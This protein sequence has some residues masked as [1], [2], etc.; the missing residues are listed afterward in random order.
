MRLGTT[1]PICEINSLDG[2]TTYA[3]RDIQGV[4]VNFFSSLYKDPG[5]DHIGDQMEVLKHYPTFCSR[6][7]EKIVADPSV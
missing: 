6:R 5:R 3:Q 1:I 7:M 2:H 4:V